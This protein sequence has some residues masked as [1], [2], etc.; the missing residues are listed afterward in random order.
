MPSLDNPG[1]FH[2]PHCG[3]KNPP[4]D[5]VLNAGGNPRMHVQFV[6]VICDG[7]MQ[8]KTPTHELADR[9]CRR[10]LSVC[11]LACEISR[12]PVVGG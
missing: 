2:C 7:V 1:I 11:I 10:I 6:T 12:V 3:T 4:Y 8:I 9:P 5:F